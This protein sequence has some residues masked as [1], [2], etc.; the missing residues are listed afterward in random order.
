M[1]GEKLEEKDDDW[2]NQVGMVLAESNFHETM[3]A[4]QIGR[5]MENIFVNGIGGCTKNI[6]VILNWN[7][8]S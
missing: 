8:K 5:I 4:F 6:W 7:L 3:N 2:K 1:D